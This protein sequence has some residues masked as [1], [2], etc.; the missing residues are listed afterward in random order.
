MF[1]MYG[2]GGNTMSTFFTVLGVTSLA[3]LATFM[4]VMLALMIK[5]GIR[6]ITQT[7]KGVYNRHKKAA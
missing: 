3:I 1:S 7:I 6:N 2:I 4:A 5:D